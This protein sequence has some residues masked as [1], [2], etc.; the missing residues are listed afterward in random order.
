M[1]GAN[2]VLRGL[3]IAADDFGHLEDGQEHTNDHATHDDAK[4]ND[5][6]RLN[7]GRQ[8]CQRGLDFFIEEVRDALE[9]VINFAGLFA[10]GDHADD[11]RRKDRVLGQRGGNAFTPLDIAGGEA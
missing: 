3:L 2:L 1:T 5:Q 11:H 6:D 8:T 9:H 4:E 7:Q 10:G